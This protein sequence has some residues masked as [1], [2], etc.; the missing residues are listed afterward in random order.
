MLDNK[1]LVEVAKKYARTP[2]QVLLR[3]ITQK[4]LSVIPKSTNLIRIEE[5]FRV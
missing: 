2:A 3:Y 1:T 4:G 5:N